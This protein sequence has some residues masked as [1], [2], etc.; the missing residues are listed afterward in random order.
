MKK[1][2]LIY[3]GILVTCSAAI[4][5]CW[6]A[7][8]APVQ[9]LTNAPLT[10]VEILQDSVNLQTLHYDDHPDII[11]IIKNTG[12]HPLIIRDIVTTCG[13]TAPQWDKSPV[14]SGKT[15]DIKVTF[16]PNSLGRFNKTIQV[17]CNTSSKIHELKLDGNVIE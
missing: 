17:L 4:I 9:E 11:F 1:T 15:K 3:I 7:F 16:K 12:K 5:T 14:L 6:L 10:T 8:T 2:H 13:C